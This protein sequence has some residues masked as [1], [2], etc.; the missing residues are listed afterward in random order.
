MDRREVVLVTGCSSGLGRALAVALHEFTTPDGSNPYKVFASARK[1]ADI[2]SLKETGVD[3]VQLDVTDAGS[4]AAAVSSIR[5]KAG[6]IDVVVN[7]AG[8][9]SAGPLVESSMQNLERA[10]DTNLLGAMRV[11]QAVVPEMMERRKGMIVN[12][13]SVA[14]HLVT[15]FAAMYHASKA[16]LLAISESLKMELSPWDIKV[17]LVEAGAFKSAL[18]E[19][20]ADAVQTYSSKESLYSPI[21]E[22][23]RDR[24]FM[25]QRDPKVMSVDAVAQQIIAAMRR[26][27]TP[28]RVPVAGNYC[29]FMFWAFL[30]K[31]VA[32]GIVDGLLQNKFGLTK[33]GQIIMGESSQTTQGSK[34]E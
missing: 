28:W 31:W 27:N 17:M 16:A 26:K 9:L 32:P 34:S 22:S 29:K 33:L 19:N 21:A 5:Q 23:I 6:R 25:S 18:S 4:V 7:N 11:I 2:D 30:Q 12:I 3:A 24:V 10:M 1:P 15:P 20:S 14:G 8:I 13:G